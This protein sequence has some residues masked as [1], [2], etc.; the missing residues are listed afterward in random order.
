MVIS[1]VVSRGIFYGL[2]YCTFI[3]GIWC[4]PNTGYATMVA[5]KPKD[6][7]QVLVWLDVIVILL[8][9]QT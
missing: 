3:V 9:K 4:D 7:S 5:Q 1:G 6:I 8:F 2:I